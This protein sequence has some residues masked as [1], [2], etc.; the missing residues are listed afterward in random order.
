[1]QE[2]GGDKVDDIGGEVYH[3]LCSL[4]SASEVLRELGYTSIRETCIECFKVIDPQ[5][6]SPSCASCHK[7]CH[8]ECLER[9]NSR[10]YRRRTAI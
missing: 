5:V 3:S 10:L 4:R 9:L 7:G 2:N 8:A 6:K 1:M